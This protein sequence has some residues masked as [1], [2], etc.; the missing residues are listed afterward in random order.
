MNLCQKFGQGSRCQLEGS[1]VVVHTSGST[2]TVRQILCRA[3]SG[4][5]LIFAGFCLSKLSCSLNFFVV[6]FHIV[7]TKRRLE[8][9]KMDFVFI[10]K[11]LS[12]HCMRNK[13][14][15]NYL[16][17]NILCNF[18]TYALH[19]LEKTHEYFVHFITYYDFCL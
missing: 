10:N 7:F 13:K 17:K 2:V 3:H 9:V 15:H 1:H 18:H 6:Q 12:Y 16:N 19:T 8:M 14:N 5:T 11:D 4:L